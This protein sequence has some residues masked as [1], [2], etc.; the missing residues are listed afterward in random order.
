MP[1]TKSTRRAREQKAMAKL[2]ADGV[3]FDELANSTTSSRK[4]YNKFDSKV[5]AP[6]RTIPRA[7]HHLTPSSTSIQLAGQ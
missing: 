5:P 3:D 7:H 4:E 1:E 6:V 2:A